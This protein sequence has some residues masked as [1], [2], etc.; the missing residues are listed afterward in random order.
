MDKSL[1]KLAVL[2]ADVSGSTRLY[3]QYGDTIARADMS[4]CIQLLD[5]VCTGMSGEA[6]KTIGDEIECAF[7]DPIK[8]ALAASEMQAGLRRAGEEGEFQ[9]GILHIKIGW[10]YGNVAWRGNDLIGEAPV[11]A[12]QVIG[13]AKADEILTS[14]HAI[15]AL[16]EALFP[17]V[18]VINRIPAEAWDGEIVVYKMP[19]EQ[20]GD[21]T[22]IA[23]KPHMHAAPIELACVLEYGAQRVRIDSD[24]HACVIGRGRQVTLQVAG[25]LTSRQHAQIALRSGRFNIRDEST[26]GTFIVYDDGT[27]THLRREEDVLSGSGTIGFGSAPEDDPDGSIRF[28]CSGGA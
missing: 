9:M 7:A 10:H 23:S 13:L 16:P 19:W 20:S 27:R 22:Q 25:R 4:A 21:E 1:K 3:E 14:K 5:D 28:E 18:H 2:Y 26:N 8:A 15:D 6:L 24:N 17:D 12:Q 11:T